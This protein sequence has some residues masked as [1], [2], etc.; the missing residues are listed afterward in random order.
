MSPIDARH[1]INDQ[2]APICKVRKG[3]SLR[4]R[5]RTRH[6]G[7][8]L[9]PTPL[10]HRDIDAQPTRAIALDGDGASAAACLVPVA[11]LAV[12]EGRVH[13]IIPRC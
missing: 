8:A 4:E 5:P 7:V 10:N 2:K 12:G 3:G 13:D 9:L 6:S 11:V 1:L